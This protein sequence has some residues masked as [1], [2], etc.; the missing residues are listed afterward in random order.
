MLLSLPRRS[1]KTRGFV[2][3]TSFISSHLTGAEQT[4]YISVEEE[5]SFYGII[6]AK[7]WETVAH[8]AGE[9]NKN[10]LQSG[11]V[12]LNPEGVTKRISS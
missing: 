6:P 7:S 9:I 11:K 5:V 4:V 1:F 2:P 3:L 12:K 8:E 10:I